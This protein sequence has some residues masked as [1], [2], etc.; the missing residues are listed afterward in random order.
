MKVLILGGTGAMGVPL[1]RMLRE[2][3][4]DVYV[5]SR[6]A[7]SP[8]PYGI[9]HIQ[10]NAGDIKFLDGLLSVETYDAVVDFI[11][12]DKDNFESAADL[13]LRKSG[14]F[15]FISSARVYAQS[16]IP[17]TEDT[18]RLLDVSEDAEYL[19]TGEYA[20][21]KAR[22]ENFLKDSEMS[23]WTVIRPTITYNSHRLQL[24][25][26]EKENWLYRALH[27]RSIVFSRDIGSKIT[28]MTYGDDVS[29][30]ISSIIGRQEAL[31]QI[32]HI[33]SPVSLPW[34]RVLEIY[35]SVLRRRLPAEQQPKVVYTETSSNLRFKEKR[36]Q[37][38]YCR[39]FNRSFDNTRISQFCDVSEFTPP[40]TGLAMCL[41]KFLDG[42][43]FR[44]IDWRLEAV[45]D[46]ISHERARLKEI[47]DVKSRISY[48]LYRYDL[49][50]LVG[51]YGMSLKIL[52]KISDNLSK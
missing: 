43:E 48:L 8:S 30:G 45:N 21:A 37:V 2:S 39:Y 5:T 20:L 51:L 9:R 38:I 7:H 27:G 40:E 22:E 34:D 33:T 31:G 18:P 52:R 47:P 19:K 42:P 12:R 25:V 36:Y 44:S 1:S 14:Q 16:D 17:I 11:V 4:N 3:G 6:S 26:L 13:I 28:T 49:V 41:D 15:V 35:L 46:R 23:N 29:R 10:G 50:F 32:Y 24:G